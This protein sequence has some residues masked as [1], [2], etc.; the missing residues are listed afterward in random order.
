MFSKQRDRG[1]GASR[2]GGAVKFVRAAVNGGSSAAWSK[3]VC[4]VYGMW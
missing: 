1:N 2:E 3:I 4:A